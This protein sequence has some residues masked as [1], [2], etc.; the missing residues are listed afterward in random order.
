M[1]AEKLLLDSD[2]IRDAVDHLCEAILPDF[3]ENPDFALLGL[4]K[5]GV[6]LA[7]RIAGYLEKKTGL[8]PPVGTLDITMYRDDIGLRSSLPLIRETLIPFNMENAKVILVDDVLSSGRAIRAA[9]D[10]VTSFGR[11]AR[12][13]LAELINRGRPEY[14]IRADY[15]GVNAFD[16]APEQKIVLKLAEN[17]GLDAAVTLQW[18]EPCADTRGE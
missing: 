14:P 18:R 12:I 11:P 16:V 1:T 3:R 15:V 2:A 7:G 13:R 5:Q 8:R 6:P 10:A 4:H 9:L 17:D